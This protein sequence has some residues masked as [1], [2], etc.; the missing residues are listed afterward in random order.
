M[1]TVDTA[2]VSSKIHILPVVLSYTL[3]KFNISL[4]K[5]DFLLSLTLAGLTGAAIDHPTVLRRYLPHSKMNLRIHQVLVQQSSNKNS[6]TSSAVA[7][8]S[9]QLRHATAFQANKNH[10]S[11]VGTV[12]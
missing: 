2:K 5:Q 3:V 9:H 12:Q 1:D 4:F 11:C 6:R 7:D 10:A 8:T